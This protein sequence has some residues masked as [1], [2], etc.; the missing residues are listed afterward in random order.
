MNTFFHVIQTRRHDGR[1]GSI[2]SSSSVWSLFALHVSALV[3]SKFF[4]FTLKDMTIGG[5]A[6]RN[7]LSEWFPVM[8]RCT[9]QGVFPPFAQLS[10]DRPWIHR[11]PDQNRVV[12]END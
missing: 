1:A 12:T 2:V 7:R 9:V 5:S 10:W 3:A 4:G 6:M 11:D 8:Q